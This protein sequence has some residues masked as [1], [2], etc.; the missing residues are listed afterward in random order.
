MKPDEIDYTIY[1][2]ADLMEAFSILKR[3]IDEINKEAAEKADS[4]IAGAEKIQAILFSRMNEAGVQNLTVKGF[5]TAYF[6]PKTFASVND[7]DKFY[8]HIAERI[9]EGENP[10]DVLGAFQRK[11]SKEYVENWVKDHGGI[12]PPG[13]TINS[14]RALQI[15]R[16]SNKT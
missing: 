8:N 10:A 3:E 11:V 13:S 6:T 2:D 7:W 15:R 1:T 12:L 9:R 5:G 16:A 14:E 4:R